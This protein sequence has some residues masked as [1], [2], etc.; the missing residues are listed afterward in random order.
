MAR[1]GPAIERDRKCGRVI[2]TRYGG[3]GAEP[4]VDDVVNDFFCTNNTAAMG[5]SVKLGSDGPVPNMKIDPTC[6]EFGV[7]PNG[8]PVH[9]GCMP[10]MS[11]SFKEKFRISV[12]GGGKCTSGQ[13]A[14]LAMG[15]S[16]EGGEYA[17]VQ[18]DQGDVASPRSDDRL[19]ASFRSRWRQLVSACQR[20]EK[21]QSSGR[22]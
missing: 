5:W 8:Q 15:R 4:T 19:A 14:G 11:Q 22:A 1:S 20:E 2:G 3:K 6:D 16:L 10:P 18:P 7:G 9:I 12:Y 13:A 17:S 21:P